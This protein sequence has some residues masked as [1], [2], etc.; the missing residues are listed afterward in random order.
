LSLIKKAN[1]FS[2]LSNFYLFC[3]SIRYRLFITPANT[4]ITVYAIN[5]VYFYPCLLQISLTIFL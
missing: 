1:K 2:R 4:N 5:V 3:E